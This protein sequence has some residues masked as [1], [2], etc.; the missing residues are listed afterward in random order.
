MPACASFE[1]F[2]HIW[3]RPA[4]SSAFLARQI[5]DVRRLAGANIQGGLFALAPAP[6]GAAEDGFA[7]PPTWLKFVCK[8]REVFR[9][10]DWLI[11]GPSFPGALPFAFRLQGS[12]I[13]KVILLFG[14]RGCLGGLGPIQ[15]EGDAPHQARQLGHLLRFRHRRRRRRVIGKD[16]ASPA[17]GKILNAST[18]A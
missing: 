3:Q 18:R 4:N 11:G 7:D 6:G 9:C 17:S 12:L 8:F 15:S 10:A 14:G 13:H 1:I 2:C 16:G 5:H